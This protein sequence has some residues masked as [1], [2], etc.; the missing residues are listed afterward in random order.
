MK[1]KLVA[2]GT[3][4]SPLEVIL[5]EVAADGNFDRLDV[6][7]AYAT[8]QGL[9][10]LRGALGGFPIKTRWIVGLDDA[11]SQPE[12]LEFLFALSGATLRLACLSP[13]RRF[14]PKLYCLRRSDNAAKR[15]SVVGSGNMTLRGLRQNGEAAALLSAESEADAEALKAQWKVLWSLGES[16]TQAKLDAYAVVYEKVKKERKKIEI[17]GV[18]PPEPQPD[19]IVPVILNGDPVSAV[20]AWLDVGSA[21]AQGREVELPRAMVPFFG[22][23]PGTGSPLHLKLKHS[24]GTT[25]SLA[26]TMRDD[27][28]MWRIGFTQAAI[29]AGTGRNSLRP[30]VGGNR[31][32]LAACFVRT[33]KQQYDV[34][35]VTI[36]SGAYKALIHNS[37]AVDA[38]YRTRKTSSGR[39]FGFY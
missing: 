31:S 21:T 22:V 30:V 5:S 6:A 27:N 9:L 33:G 11:I 29:S 4:E 23:G 13:Q 37:E 35:F 38:H 28:A 2:Q 20:H 15:V 10:T 8:K 39:S 14:H 19:A 16:A 12:A 3:D 17:L 32:D 34:T 24:D 18:A 1:V 25:H 7:V 36:G 26:L